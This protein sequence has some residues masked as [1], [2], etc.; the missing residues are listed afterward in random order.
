MSRVSILACLAG[1]HPANY[2]DTSGPRYARPLAAP[3]AAVPAALKVVSFNIKYAIE[4]DSAI[5]L[6][7]SDPAVMGADM[8]LLQEMDAPGTGR[9]AEALGMGFVYYPASVRPSG[10]DFGNAVLSRWPIEEDAKIVLPHRGRL[11][12]SSRTA[13]AATLRIGG[14]RVRV[15]SVHLATWAEASPSARRGQI[16]AV[17]ADAARYDRVIIGGDMNNHGVGRFLEAHAYDWPTERGPKTVL[18]GRWDHL[19]LKGVTLADPAAT[20]TVMHRRGSSD[21]RPVWAVVRLR[22]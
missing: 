10:R 11:A 13:T 19:F 8:V 6:L 22:D 21:H 7:R 20:G 1:C 4:V 9:V 18:L 17:L 3:A 2:L 12:G 5:A 16:A 14:E 15:Y